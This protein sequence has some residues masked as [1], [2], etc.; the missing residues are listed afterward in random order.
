MHTIAEIERLLDAGKL[1]IQMRNGNWWAIR[2]NGATKRWKRD[3]ERFAIPIKFGLKFCGTITDD[4]NLDSYAIEHLRAITRVGA[5][6]VLV[7]N[8]TAFV[9]DVYAQCEKDL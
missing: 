2:R 4:T 6:K 5:A 3:T 8:L 7:D 1:E 9:V